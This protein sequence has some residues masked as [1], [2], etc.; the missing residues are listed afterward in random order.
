MGDLLEETQDLSVEV[1]RSADQQLAEAG[2]PTLTQVRLQFWKRIHAIMDR[3]R[4]RS[5]L[6]YHLMKNVADGADEPQRAKAW[7]II[8][9]YEL[10]SSKL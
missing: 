6:E 1:V 4:V 3:G 9:A 10:K 5:E 2:L 8:G 7:A